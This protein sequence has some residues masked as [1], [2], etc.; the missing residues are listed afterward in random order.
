MELDSESMLDVQSQVDVD[1]ALQGAACTE[2]ANVSLGGVRIVAVVWIVGVRTT[3]LGMGRS[4]QYCGKK[5]PSLLY[6]C[7]LAWRRRGGEDVGWS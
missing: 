2:G 3:L 5:S 6:L 1:V 7:G 4:A